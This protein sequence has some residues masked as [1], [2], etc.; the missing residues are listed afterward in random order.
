M[1]TQ[2]FGKFT[3]QW[4]LDAFALVMWVHLKLS[5]L[6]TVKFVKPNFQRM[7]EANSITLAKK[8]Y[9]ALQSPNEI[10]NFYG[11]EKELETMW[12]EFG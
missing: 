12:R 6:K 5:Q 2:L 4:K 7:T 1:G 9:E 11:Y 8:R 3:L 10:D